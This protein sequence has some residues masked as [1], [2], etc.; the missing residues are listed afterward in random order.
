MIKAGVLLNL[1]GIVL[2]S[3]AAFYLAPVL[4]E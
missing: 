3:V 4:V 2:V 1:M